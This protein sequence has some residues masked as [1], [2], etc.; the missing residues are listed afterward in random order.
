MADIIRRLIDFNQSTAALTAN[1]VTL[2]PIST[3]AGFVR[4]ELAE[5]K[6]SEDLAVGNDR[7]V[8]RLP[9]TV[10]SKRLCWAVP[11]RRSL[12]AVEPARGHGGGPPTTST[13]PVTPPLASSRRSHERSE[14]Q[15]VQLLMTGN[16]AGLTAGPPP[17]AACKQSRRNRS[18]SIT[19]AVTPS[20]HAAGCSYE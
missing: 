15:V 1:G 13:L 3:L 5:P 14:G 19:A 10:A 4:G 6:E 17:R 9:F 8:L 20:Y 7:R 2:G 11:T 12:N 16:I 18:V